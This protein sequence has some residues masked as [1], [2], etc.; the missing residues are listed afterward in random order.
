MLQPD[1][2]RSADIMLDYCGDDAFDEIANC[3]LV[4]TELGDLEGA[5]GWTK[6][7]EA[8]LS[9]SGGSAALH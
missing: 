6:V 1:I 9:R 2:I 3:I 4:C 5:D 7:I 8:V